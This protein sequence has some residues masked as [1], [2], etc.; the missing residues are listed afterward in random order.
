[1]IDPRAVV[2]PLRP[3]A[4]ACRIDRRRGRPGSI[5][6][7]RVVHVRIADGRRSNELAYDVVVLRAG[8]RSR[9][10]PIPGLAE[11]GDRVQDGAGSDLPAEPGAVATGR[12]GRVAGRRARRAALTFV[13]VGAGYAGVEALGE[14][15]DLA[16]DA[17]EHYPTL[18]SAEMRWVLVEAAT[19]SSRSS[20]AG[21]P[22]TPRGSAAS[23]DRDPTSDTRLESAEG[24]V[25]RLSTGEAFAA[26][27]L[28]WTAGVKPSP[29][30]RDSADCPSTSTAASRWTDSC[31]S[32]GCTTRGRPAMPPRC[33][34]ARTGGLS[35]PT[36]QHAPP[37]GQAARPRTSTAILA[38]GPLAAVRLRE[39]SAA[40]V[41][42]AATKASRPSMGVKVQGVPRV[43]PASLLP[44]AARC[45]RRTARAD[46]D[47]LDGGAV[48]P[49]G[50]RAARIARRSAGAVPTRG[51]PET[52]P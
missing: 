29:L 31:G 43:V 14:L 36:A 22:R 2:V 26:E 19:G 3:R 11:H 49:A 5:T 8:S 4:A 33:P 28:V 15:E 42:S 34:D 6:R 24:G 10:L 32:M 18:R 50:P 40:S 51:G 17:I 37:A 13:F 38:G 44:P 48:L 30:A 41:R 39:R 21:S 35:P 46:R 27:T 16:R 25:I 7:P 52:R 1:M 45:R 20:R 9:V 47:G 23:G 12:R